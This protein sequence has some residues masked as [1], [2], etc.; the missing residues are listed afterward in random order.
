MDKPN[1]LNERLTLIAN[2]SV[3]VGIRVS[4]LRAKAEHRGHPG[5]DAGLDH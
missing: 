3:V 1:K 2:L 5:T 4:S